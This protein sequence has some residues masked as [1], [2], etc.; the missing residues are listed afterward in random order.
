MTGQA[1][2][3]RGQRRYWLIRRFAWLLA[4]IVPLPLVLLALAKEAPTLLLVDLPVGIAAGGW[5]VRFWSRDKLTMWSVL[6]ERHRW[7]AATSD[8]WPANRAQAL[9][10]LAVHPDHRDCLAVAALLKAGRHEEARQV[11]VELPESTD[12]GRLFAR[13]VDAV[14]DF[15][16][17]APV[18]LEELAAASE[19]IEDPEAGLRAQAQVASLGVSLSWRGDMPLKVALGRVSKLAPALRLTNRQLVGLLVLDFSG[20]VIALVLAMVWLSLA[21]HL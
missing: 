6:D 14:V 2:F 12:S 20:L 10:W 21:G 19:A 17:G 8:P 7:E 11:Q 15:A 3:L 13:M 1:R 5:N 18:D 9:R 4:L 16:K